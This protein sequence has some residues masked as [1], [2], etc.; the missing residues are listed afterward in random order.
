MDVRD[1]IALRKPRDLS[2]NK[3]LST[4][5][6]RAADAFPEP[7]IAFRADNKYAGLAS[8]WMPD[9]DGVRGARRGREREGVKRGGG[10]SLM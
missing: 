3:A 1:L 2:S 4:S 5:N 10:G 9:E 8:A 6:K 7:D